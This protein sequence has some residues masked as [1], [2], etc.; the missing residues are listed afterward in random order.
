[1]IVVSSKLSELVLCFV[2]IMCR[3]TRFII[4][5]FESEKLYVVNF[6]HRQT[7]RRLIGVINKIK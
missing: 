4:D 6:V 7:L 5:D 2:I 3:V 1:M